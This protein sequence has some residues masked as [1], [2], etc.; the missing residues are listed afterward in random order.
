[1][2]F[3]DDD[4]I[5]EEMSDKIFKECISVIAKARNRDDSRDG[6][7]KVYSEQ[8]EYKNIPYLIKIMRYYQVG[9]KLKKIKGNNRINKWVVIEHPNSINNLIS[10]VKKKYKIVHDVDYSPDFLQADTRHGGQEDW[11][12]RK[13]VIRMHTEAKNNINQLLY[14]K[15]IKRNLKTFKISNFIELKFIYNE[16]YIY[17][18]NKRFDQCKYLLLNFPINKIEEYINIDSIDEASEVLDK[19]ME[20]ELIENQRISPEVEFWGHCSNLQAWYENNYDTRLL[21]RNLAFLLLKKLADIGDLTAKKVF[22]DEIAMRL[23]SGNKNVIQYL[24]NKKYTTYLTDDEL[25]SL[26]LTPFC[27]NLINKYRKPSTNGLEK[28]IE[29]YQ[30]LTEI[31]VLHRILD[32]ESLRINIP[33][34][35]GNLGLIPYLKSM[36]NSIKNERKR[37]KKTKI[38]SVICLTILN[39]I[40]FLFLIFSIIYLPR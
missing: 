31:D 10:E 2:K 26:S 4:H 40:C 16:T 25:N 14:Y 20:R 38:Y 27:K 22:K 13:M 39:L 12:L 18:N 36:N 6:H 33:E 19:S 7:I 11:T 32:A 5:E 37:I 30:S 3:I 35:Q 15:N 29:E 23:E 9:I 21:H 17:I 24:F 1:M 34:D 8:F 28:Q